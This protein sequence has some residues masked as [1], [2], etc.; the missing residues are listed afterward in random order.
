MNPLQNT[1][2]EMARD[3]FTHMPIRDT[4]TEWAYHI[5][6]VQEINMQSESMTPTDPATWDAET[7]LLLPELAKSHQ[8]IAD[9]AFTVIDK[10]WKQRWLPQGQETIA[11]DPALIQQIKSRLDLV[12]VLQQHGTVLVKRGKEF[13]GKCP[14]HDDTNASLSVSSAYQVWRCYGACN[15]GGDVLDYLQIKFNLD[16]MSAFRTAAALTHITLPNLY[17]EI[18]D[19]VMK[20]VL[21]LE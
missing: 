18:P 6:R 5:T 19:S 13:K 2:L 20:M 11:I 7:Y 16:W 21:Q 9:A 12:A 1:P 3:R 4:A 15:R 8:S 17:P 14:M 10:R